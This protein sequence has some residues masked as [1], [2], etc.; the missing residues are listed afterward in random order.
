M[1]PD[2]I[3][4]LVAS[5]REEAEIRQRIN[6]SSAEYLKLLKDIKAINKNIA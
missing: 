3:K 1:S 2:E 4:K 5:M 6:E